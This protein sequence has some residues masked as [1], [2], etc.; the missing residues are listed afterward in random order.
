MVLGGPSIG[1]SAGGLRPRGRPAHL[2]DGTP[3]AD[4]STAGLLKMAQMLPSNNIFALLSLMEAIK[5]EPFDPAEAIPHMPLLLVAGEKD[6]VPPPCPNWQSW[7]PSG[8]LVES[9]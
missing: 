8:G 1:G 9:C 5:G 3:I 6:D 2:A 4:E 7:A